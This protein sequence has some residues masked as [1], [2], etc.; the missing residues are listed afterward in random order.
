MKALTVSTKKHLLSQLHL[1]QDIGYEFEDMQ[2]L[3]TYTHLFRKKK[4][5]II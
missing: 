5:K 4:T 3:S 1:W 2:M